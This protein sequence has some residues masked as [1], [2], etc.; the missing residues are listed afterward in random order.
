MLCLRAADIPRLRQTPGPAPKVVAPARADEAPHAHQAGEALGERPALRRRVRSAGRRFENPPPGPPGPA[1]QE[2]GR[3]RRVQS[4]APGVGDRRPHC[5]GKEDDRGPPQPPPAARQHPDRQRS[6][7]NYAGVTVRT[8]RCLLAR[9]WRR[10]PPYRQRH[11]V[12]EADGP[13]ETEDLAGWAHAP[14]LRSQVVRSVG[15]RP[16]VT[17][18][19]GVFPRPRAPA[20]RPQ[21]PTHVA[22]RQKPPGAFFERHRPAERT[23]AQTVLVPRCVGA[24]G[25]SRTTST[26]PSKNDAAT[27]IGT[28]VATSMAMWSP[29]VRTVTPVT[30]PMSIRCDA[31][32]AATPRSAM[33]T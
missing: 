27:S 25:V 1:G 21:R 28:R 9:S 11:L 24:R 18:S 6:K 31:G 5:E 2:H 22:A 10:E 12:D 19:F 26:V 3:W 23:R 17:G 14:P 8:H 13:S 15:R 20:R 33:T 7:T 16:G 32:T 4:G 29:S 30:G